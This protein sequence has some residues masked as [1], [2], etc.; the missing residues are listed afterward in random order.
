MSL[1]NALQGLNSS[2]FGNGKSSIGNVDKTTLASLANGESS[3]S[4]VVGNFSVEN[5]QSASDS[6]LSAIAGTDSTRSIFAEIE[7]ETDNT[8]ASALT[9]LVDSVD[10]KSKTAQTE[11]ED[12]MLGR[13]DNIH[14]AMISMQEASI[15]F[16]IMVQVRNKL[17]DAYKQ[18][19]QMS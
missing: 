2:F 17:V 15:S 6:Q 3:I 7:P 12:I 4:D 8:F 13:S 10:E 11:A 5:V 1:I 18:L 9:S 19:S 16:D 14:Q